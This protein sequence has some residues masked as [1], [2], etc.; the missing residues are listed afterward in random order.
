MLVIIKEYIAVGEA[1]IE[2]YYNTPD[3]KQ[4]LFSPGHFRN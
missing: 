1:D 2:Y 3:L 4:N